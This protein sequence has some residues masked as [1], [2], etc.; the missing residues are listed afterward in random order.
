MTVQLLTKEYSKTECQTVKVSQHLK[1][2]HNFK[3]NGKMESMSDYYDIFKI[4]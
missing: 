4:I 2:A 1:M 3:H